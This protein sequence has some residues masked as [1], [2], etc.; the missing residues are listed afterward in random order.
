MVYTFF[1]EKKSKNGDFLKASL[2]QKLMNETLKGREQVH[3]NE[4]DVD[5]T[6]S[7]SSSDQGETMTFEEF[8]RYLSLFFAS[9]HNLAE[10][11]QSYLNASHGQTSALSPA[12]VEEFAS[13]LSL[14]YGVSAPDSPLKSEETS[15][16]E[17]VGEI[18]PSLEASTFVKWDKQSE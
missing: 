1:A 2:V 13:F 17:F 12:E 14:F 16:D 18:L 7:A 3:A 8:I 5:R 4:N 9:A 11:I 15:I 10:R 6:I